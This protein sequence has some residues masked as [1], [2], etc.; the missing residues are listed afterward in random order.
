MYTPQG[1]AT[2]RMND[3]EDIDRVVDAVARAVA[4]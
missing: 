2:G 1:Y 4:D 3:Y